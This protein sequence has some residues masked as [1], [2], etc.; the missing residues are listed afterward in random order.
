[1]TALTPAPVQRREIKRR[2]EIERCVNKKWERGRERQTERQR[3][4]ERDV[5]VRGRDGAAESG[6]V[7]VSLWEKQHWQNFKSCLWRCSH[8][9][10]PAVSAWDSLKA[11]Q[12]LLGAGVI[13]FGAER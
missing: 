1:M 10:T 12:T 13:H 3:A 2:R 11:C 9:L 5:K 8:T 6:E 4:Q 7:R